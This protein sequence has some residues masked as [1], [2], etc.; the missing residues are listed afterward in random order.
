LGII[1]QQ[2]WRQAVRFLEVRT[3]DRVII[4]RFI[5]P[6]SVKWL[7]LF[8]FVIGLICLVG[9]SASLPFIVS[10][11]GFTTGVILAVLGLTFGLAAIFA[12][13][14]NI[15]STRDGKN[16]DITPTH[17]IKKK[18]D[19]DIKFMDYST[20]PPTEIA[21]AKISGEGK[22]HR[23]T[24][25]SQ[26]ESRTIITDD[27]TP[28]TEI[29]VGNAILEGLPKDS[30]GYLQFALF[31]NSKRARVVFN[32]SNTIKKLQL[33][34][35]SGEVNTGVENE[36]CEVNACV[37][38]GQLNLGIKNKIKGSSSFWLKSGCLNLGTKNELV[39]SGITVESGILNTGN[40]NKTS[41]LWLLNK[42]GNCNLGERN[43]LNGYQM[44][45]SRDYYLGSS[46]IINCNTSG[47]VNN[48]GLIVGN[49]SRSISNSGIILGRCCIL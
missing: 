41:R 28:D 5:S 32:T 34:I 12:F 49:S 23:I 2:F 19:A 7:G 42:T 16:I 4:G 3:P 39:Q 27:L 14:V 38:S 13:Q 26:D 48:T 6:P 37:E 21:S 43:I 46:N 25:N 44:T 45:N 18:Q 22:E 24:I 15:R 35:Q 11:I 1:E 40:R 33:S 29:K 10:T 36:L 17:I 8:L 47:K 20:V 9:V 31:D 30:N